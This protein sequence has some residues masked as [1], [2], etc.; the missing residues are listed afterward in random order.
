MLLVIST[1]DMSN[2]SVAKTVTKQSAGM[3]NITIGYFQYN[4]GYFRYFH[5]TALDLGDVN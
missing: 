4:I 2:C 1:H 3:E 5:F